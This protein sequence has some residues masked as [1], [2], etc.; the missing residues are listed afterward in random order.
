MWLKGINLGFSYTLKKTQKEA[1]N[2][3][4]RASFFSIFFWDVIYLNFKFEFVS[5]F[6]IVL[7]HFPEIWRQKNERLHD[8]TSFLEK[9]KNGLQPVAR[10]VYNL[11]QDWFTRPFRNFPSGTE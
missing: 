4:Y 9:N 2:L 11:L 10:L 3:S 8:V 6:S 5:F 1:F 7:H